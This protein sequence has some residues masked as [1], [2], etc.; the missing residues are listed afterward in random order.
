MSLPFLI[1]SIPRLIKS[2][3]ILIYRM[4]KVGSSS[5]Y[6]SI[7]QKTKNVFHVH[8]M[9]PSNIQAVLQGSIRIGAK[10]PDDRIGLLLH[11]WIVLPR[12]PAKLI[13]LFRE[14]VSRNISAF[15]Q[16]LD[17]FNNLNGESLELNADELIKNFL[18]NY[19]HKVPLEWFDIEMYQTTGINV[20]K[21]EFPKCKGYQIVDLNPYK[22][23]LMRH[24]LDDRK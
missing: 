24:D 11:K 15:F 5:I 18:I 4:G 21:I 13:S 7:R 17:Y 22:L 10:P 1:S 23:L 3:P 14:P 19:Q 8:R 6:T 9:S 16:N 12:R 20:Y 2:D